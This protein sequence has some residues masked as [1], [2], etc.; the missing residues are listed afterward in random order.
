MEQIR[1]IIINNLKKETKYSDTSIEKVIEQIERM[2]IK[3]SKLFAKF[4]NKAFDEAG[5]TYVK[6]LFELTPELAADY[7]KLNKTMI[8]NYTKDITKKIIDAMK[9]KYEKISNK[10][11]AT[12]R[13][14]ITNTIL[15]EIKD[16]EK[17]LNLLKKEIIYR[18]Q[19][20]NLSLIDKR[21]KRPF[22]CTNLNLNNEEINVLRNLLLGKITYDTADASFNKAIIKISKE[23]EFFLKKLEYKSRINKEYLSLNEI[24]LSLY[25]IRVLNILSIDYVSDLIELNNSIEFRHILKKFKEPIIKALSEKNIIIPNKIEELNEILKLENAGIK[26]Q[27][28]QGITK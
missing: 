5:I 28:K 13:E 14:Q 6:D 19:Y 17:I 20:N 27:I 15:K 3:E 10:K 9:I 8:K 12:K 18:E 7:L 25:N 16:E 22:Y 21:I 2:K 1:E 4:L 23:L 26:K 11:Q 24:N